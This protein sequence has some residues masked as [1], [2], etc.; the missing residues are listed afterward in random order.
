MSPIIRLSRLT[1]LGLLVSSA[2]LGNAKEFS[3]P[4]NFTTI[5]AALDAA[6]A[7]DLVRASPGTYLETSISNRRTSISS[8]RR[9]PR[10]PSSTRPG[11]PA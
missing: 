2:Q 11:K 4:G 1:T 10:P 3:V 6:A 8:A 5:Q 9:G 7:G